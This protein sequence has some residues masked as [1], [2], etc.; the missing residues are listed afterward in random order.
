YITSQTARH[1][2]RSARGGRATARGCTSKRGDRMC[3]MRITWITCVVNLM[4]AAIVAAA[5]TTRPVV[6]VR[7]DAFDAALTKAHDVQGAEL[8]QTLAPVASRFQ[9]VDVCTTPGR[10]M[11][12]I[13]TLNE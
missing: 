4:A 8:Q 6:A 7:D 9:S 3:R 10:N 13:R 1:V 12:S 11:W 2:A 5:P